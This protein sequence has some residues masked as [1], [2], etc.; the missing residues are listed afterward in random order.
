MEPQ[1]SPLWTTRTTLDRKTGTWRDAIP[2]YRTLPSPCLGACPVNGHIA[3]WIGHIRKQEYHAAWLVLMDNNPFPAIAGRI[4]HH[5]CE[6]ACN[7]QYLDE[8]IS[9]CALERFVGDMALAKDWSLPSSDLVKKEKVAVVGAGP[10]GLSAAYQLRRRGLQVTLF[11]SQNQLG[12]LMRYGIP[13]YRLEKRVLDGEIQRILDLGVIVEHRPITTQQQLEQLQNSFDAIYLATGAARSKTLPVLDYAKPWVIDSVEFLAT[14]NANKS[15]PTGQHLI[16][17]GGGSAAM[18]VARTAR[19][20]GKSVTV[21]TL[22][23]AGHLPAQHTEVEEALEEGIRFVSGAMLQQVNEQT[24]GLELT[25]IEVE[26]T[27]GYRKGEFTIKPKS[28]TAFTLKANAIVPSIGQDAN[29]A[30]WGES[31]KAQGPILKT[32][33]DWQTEKKGI[34][35]GGDLASMER[36]VTHAVGMGKQAAAAIAHYLEGQSPTSDE[37]TVAAVSIDTINTYYYPQQDRIDQQKLPSRQRLQNFDEV[38]QPLQEVQ[39]DAEAIRC[40]SCGTCIY[41]DNCYAYCPD[42]AITKLEK[43]YAIKSDYCKGCGL[44]V[45]ECPTGSIVMQKEYEEIT[46]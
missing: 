29:Y 26:F 9:I 23:P 11:E 2:D 18:D 3:D 19:R 30:I 17:I 8:S 36:F 33:S 40:F 10:A 41:C 20:L 14:T 43:G 1:A 12:G 22:E 7:R 35:A 25:C 42:M 31:F 27:A 39:A 38:Q 24:D 28:G 6:T 37:K 5:P 16:V 4:C 15:H 45:A 46:Q 34:F 13:A 44:C 21:L 32:G